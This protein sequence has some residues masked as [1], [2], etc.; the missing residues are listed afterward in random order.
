MF[1]KGI[2]RQFFCSKL[3]FS[4]DSFLKL[5]QALKYTFVSNYRPLSYLGEQSTIS[6]YLFYIVFVILIQEA[7]HVLKRVY[8]RFSLHVATAQED[9]AYALY[10][11]EYSSGRFYKAREHAERAIR[12]LEVRGIQFFLNIYKGSNHYQYIIVYSIS[13]KPYTSSHCMT[14]YQILFCYLDKC[15]KIAKLCKES[16]RKVTFINNNCF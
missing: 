9:L 16:N 12:I 4:V 1:F 5:F 10:V 2:R 11:L 14:I 3:L 7:L 13:I 8:G 15:G 6:N